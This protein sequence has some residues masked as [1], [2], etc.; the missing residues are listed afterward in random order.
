MTLFSN[1]VGGTVVQAESAVN[2]VV[3]GSFA[4][5][6]SGWTGPAGMGTL[7]NEGVDD[8]SSVRITLNGFGWS[9]FYSPMTVEANT[10]YIVTF[11]SRGAAQVRV[12]VDRFW[13][14]PLGYTPGTKNWVVNKVYFR[15]GDWTATK[16]AILV[17]GGTGTA[18]IDNFSCYKLS[19][20]S[21]MPT[22]IPQNLGANIYASKNSNFEATNGSGVPAQ[23]GG[24]LDGRGLG[25]NGSNAFR[26][27]PADGWGPQTSPINLSSYIGQTLRITYKAKP[28]TN[29]GN[30]AQV[31]VSNPGLTRIF[32]QELSTSVWTPRS[33]D[34][35]VTSDRN[36]DVVGFN[37]SGGEVLI[38]DLVIAPILGE[39]GT[40]SVP[41]A[42]PLA[43]ATPTPVEIA[44]STPTPVTTA[45]PEPTAAPTAGATATPT[46]APTATPIQDSNI[47]LNVGFENGLT[48][49]YLADNEND[50]IVATDVARTGTNSAKCLGKGGWYTL[51]QGWPTTVI[52]ITPN[53]DYKVTFYVKAGTP[54]GGKLAFNGWFGGWASA[55]GVIAQ[56]FDDVNWTKFETTF[57]SGTNTQMAKIC[58]YDIGDGWRGDQTIYI[59]DVS[60]A[61][62]IAPATP[63]PTA[64]PTAAPTVDPNATPTPRL[65]LLLRRHLHLHLRRRLHLRRCLETRQ[66]SYL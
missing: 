57:S 32:G 49:W 7:I 40:A 1:I 30:D 27:S 60:I 15:S 43:T 55:F 51:N 63:T 23:W 12:G 29:L 48:S 38:D 4:N 2:Y 36:A 64:T 14:D 58:F 56:T 11:Y 16:A 21:A 37:V 22:D 25:V 26:I 53:T 46:V 54:T 24:T 5:D 10:D 19:D 62:Y 39:P 20:A 65:H 28:I 61:P 18:D 6:L 41:T 47:L 3:N 35:V 34:L 8:S 9:Y 45:T 33:F 59:D 17:T 52:S 50:Y 31:F 42:E 13:A 44:T 66:T